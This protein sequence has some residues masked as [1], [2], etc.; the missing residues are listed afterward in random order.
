MHSLYKGAK[1][2]FYQSSDKLKVKCEGFSEGT[3][4][5]LFFADSKQM[6]RH[7][8]IFCRNINGYKNC[9]LYPVIMKQYESKEDGDE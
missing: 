2:P 8:K 7:T 9:P 5:G 6:N 4:I 1:C 3:R